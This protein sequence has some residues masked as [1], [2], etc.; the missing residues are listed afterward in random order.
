[1][2]KIRKNHEVVSMSAILFFFPDVNSATLSWTRATNQIA[3]Q[4]LSTSPEY[5]LIKNILNPQKYGNK[6]SPDKLNLITS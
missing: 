5:M 1:M 4:G 3:E 2:Y 6:I